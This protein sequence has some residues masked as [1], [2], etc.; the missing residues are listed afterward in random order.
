MGLRLTLRGSASTILG[1]YPSKSLERS[2]VLCLV[3]FIFYFLSLIGSSVHRTLDPQRAVLIKRGNALL[4]RNELRTALSSRRLDEFEDAC[5]AGPS[6]HEG[7]GSCAR[8]V[9]AL[10]ANAIVTRFVRPSL[11]LAFI[12]PSGAVGFIDWLDGKQP[13]ANMRWLLR[14]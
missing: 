11:L 14:A 7:S 9:A 13:E 6:F 3:R 12:D 10:K 4:G 1:K 8:P 5:L 2:F